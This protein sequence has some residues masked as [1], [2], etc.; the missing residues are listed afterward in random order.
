MTRFGV[1]S[2]KSVSEG[3]TGLGTMKKSKMPLVKRQASVHDRRMIVEE[4]EENQTA[5]ASRPLELSIR[6]SDSVA[7]TDTEGSTR[8][9]TPAT[10]TPLTPPEAG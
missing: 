3:R 6:R 2:V 8:P 1:A 5:T 7:S 4:E 10:P 9:P